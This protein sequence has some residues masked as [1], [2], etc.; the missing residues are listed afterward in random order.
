L[1][2]ENL[3]LA[4]VFF[5][6][7][8]DAEVDP[9]DTSYVRNIPD[10]MWW[11]LATMTTVG[12]GDK[13]PHSTL[14]RVISGFGA[15]T[16]MFMIALPVAILGINFQRVYNEHTEELRI[17]FLKEQI[18]GKKNLSE[19]QRELTFLNERIA[20]LANGNIQIKQLLTRSDDLY[21]IVAREFRQLYSAVFEEEKKENLL[22]TNGG[23]DA[24]FFGLNGKIKL[25]E[26]LHRA[27]KKIKIKQ[28]FSRIPTSKPGVKTFVVPSK[29]PVPPRKKSRQLSWDQVEEEMA[30]TNR[31]RDT[32]KVPSIKI[33]LGRQS[34][35]DSNMLST[36]MLRSDPSKNKT[37]I[38]GVLNKVLE[39]DPFL[40]EDGEVE[41]NQV[42]NNDISRSIFCIERE[43]RNSRDM[44]SGRQFFVKSNSM[45]NENSF[46]KY[47]LEN[48]NFLNNHML[49]ELLLAEDENQSDYCSSGD[50]TPMTV[51]KTNKNQDSLYKNSLLRGQNA[52]QRFDSSGF[53]RNDSNIT[54]ANRK[55][56]G[57]DRSSH[58]PSPLAP[59]ET[60]IVM[61]RS[62]KVAMRKTRHSTVV[63]PDSNTWK[64]AEKI[65]Q[66]EKSKQEEYLRTHED[67]PP[68]QRRKGTIRDYFL[69]LDEPYEFVA[70]NVSGKDPKEQH[71]A[72]KQSI[73]GPP[74]Q[75]I[76]QK[77]TVKWLEDEDVPMIIEETDIT[78][79]ERRPSFT[80]RPS[81]AKPQAKQPAKRK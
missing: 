26:R 55:N 52:F 25:M 22:Q 3:I 60:L 14:G 38:T 10:A 42:N 74:K 64:L 4:T 44:N 8:S 70:D 34:S 48:L 62:Q 49:N 11:A 59:R 53:H 58:P 16:G 51:E 41:I 5:Y 9:G 71:P 45:E 50:S 65:Y 23:E 17:A 77:K 7:E 79:R 15:L 12:Y 63:N 37:Y 20:T 28:L 1:L 68:G 67:L 40:E 18:G 35:K 75:V 69:D 73:A 33:S 57:T 61:D 78:T 56:K 81:M 54:I 36:N 27:K 80:N 6:A 19:D 24:A 46:I 66:R 76:F 13:Y 32:Q 29:E 47:K 30:S 72:S 31:D 43:R 21:K 2:I 39:T